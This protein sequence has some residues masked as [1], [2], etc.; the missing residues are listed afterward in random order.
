MIRNYII[1]LELVKEDF[2][3]LSNGEYIDYGYLYKKRVFCINLST[4]T[5]EN[6]KL[7]ELLNALNQ[8]EF[9]R[10][11]SYVFSPYFNNST[12]ISK[13]FRLLSKYYPAFKVTK[14]EI[15]ENI[16]PDEDYK[17]KKI[18]DL[19]SRMLKLL[20][21]FFANEEF[22]GKSL[23]KTRFTL[24]QLSDRNMEKHFASKARE[25]DIDIGKEKIVS[26]D[27][28]FDKYAVFRQKREYFEP[29][30]SR[31]NRAAY[32]QDITTEIN[33]LQPSRFTIS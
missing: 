24:K 20:E 15:F 11:E 10:F 31:K 4:M 28:L 12:Q 27:Q 29:L 16:F 8:A 17:D 23:L 25:A 3:L 7:A 32:F 5:I 13:L 18:R 2:S 21:D 9:K 33:L 1:N 22:S 30:K 6:S 14:E 19:F 26:S